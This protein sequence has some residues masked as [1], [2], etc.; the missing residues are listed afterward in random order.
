M[1]ISPAPPASVPWACRTEPHL[2]IAPVEGPE[3][4]GDHREDEDAGLGPHGAA[5]EP[6]GPV[7]RRGQ[8][9]AWQRFS[10]ITGIRPAEDEERAEVVGEMP[11]DR[12]PDAAR[13]ADGEAEEETDQRD[14]E[15]VH[16]GLARL[17]KIVVGAEAHGEEDG[18]GPE[19]HPPAE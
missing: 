15:Q 19:P 1:G 6:V 17:E 12:P 14:A 18:A 2:R 11:A 8:E 3:E 9:V 10:V 7:E 16:P 4:H 5:G 13:A